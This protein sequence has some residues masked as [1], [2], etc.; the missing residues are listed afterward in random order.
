MCQEALHVEGSLL[1]QHEIDGSAELRGKNRQSLGFAVSPGQAAELLL[2]LRVAA[3]EQHR[4]LGEGPLQMNVSDLGSTRAEL[5]AR[6][7]VIA[8]DQAA[9]GKKV[10]NSGESADVVDLVEDRERQNLADPRDRAEAMEG[11]WIVSLGLADQMELEL[12]NDLVGCRNVPEA[13]VRT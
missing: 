6:G 2:T 11:V 1:G 13:D 9:V 10:L 5:L 4:G 12:T 3:E 7:A 8:L